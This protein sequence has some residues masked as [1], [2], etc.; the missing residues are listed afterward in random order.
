VGL[1]GAHRDAVGRARLRP[2]R[3]AV[4]LGPPARGDQ[5]GDD[6]R[7][8][9]RRAR[10]RPAPP[11]R[12]RSGVADRSHGDRRPSR[13]RSDDRRVRAG[14]QA[15]RRRGVGLP[16]A[17]P[18]AQGRRRGGDQVR[19]ALVVAHRAGR[20][21][22]PGPGRSGPLGRRGVRSSSAARRDDRRTRRPG[23]TAHASDHG[24]PR[25]AGGRASR[26]A[27]RHGRL[28]GQ[29]LQRPGGPH[30]PDR[31][32][33]RPPGRAAPRDHLSAAGR[34]IAR[35]RRAP[36]GA[37]QVLQSA[38]HARL[39]ERAVLDA[40]TTERPCRRKAN[41][42]PGS[43]ALAEAARLRGHDLAGVVVDL[44]DYARIARVAR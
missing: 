35:H 29:P 30:R 20:L 26:L 2:R 43:A 38:K 6:L 16:A 32:R 40:F 19:H 9:R 18:A 42:P 7:A 34:R 12:H 10:R 24:V 37:G 36:A 1:A 5:R 44:E 23:A 21:A 11:G 33:P 13:Q 22:G 3:R 4:L 31:H 39:L 8:P 28:R 25:T 27:H 41:R 15:F 17:P 14:R